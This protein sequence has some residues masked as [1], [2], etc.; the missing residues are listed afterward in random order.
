MRAASI[1]VAAALAAVL[2]LC[3]PAHARMCADCQD[4]MFR[5]VMTTASVCGHNVNHG[6]VKYCGACSAR[7]GLCEVCG[8]ALAAVDKPAPTSGPA[9]RPASG[10][11]TKPAVSEKAAQLAA[12][13]KENAA[14]FTMNVDYMGESDKPFYCLYLSVPEF[15]RARADQFRPAVVITAKTAGKI[16]DFLA[17]NGS[18][19]KA[20]DITGKN[21]QRQAGPCYVATIRYGQTTLS[22][23]LG[24]GLDTI[25]WLEG[26]KEALADE[27]AAVDQMDLLLGRLSGLRKLWEQEAAKK[28]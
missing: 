18:L 19:D 9:S 17:A 10:P 22:L 3:P 25:K 20:V 6:G 14:S 2:A 13:I 21:V 16:A 27:K 24:W 7:L 15:K 11:A 4:M 26:L 5:Q 28:P 8:K 12:A 23:E 1:V